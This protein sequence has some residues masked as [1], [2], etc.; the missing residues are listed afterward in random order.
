MRSQARLRPTTS[1][2]L[3]AVF[4][5]VGH[6][7]FEGARVLDLYAGSGRF[8]ITA[9]GYGATFVRFVDLSRRN[10]A[11]LRAAIAKTSDTERW[12]VI[13]GDVLKTLPVLEGRHDIVFADPPYATDPFGKLAERLCENDLLE[14]EAVVIFEHF[15]KSVTSNKLFNLHKIKSRNYGD[16]QISVYKFR[17]PDGEDG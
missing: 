7:R 16:S 2:V 17:K 13:S 3:N 11:A 14:S 5:M 4:S 8:G 10:C 6:D 12:R 15:A 9:L 1:K